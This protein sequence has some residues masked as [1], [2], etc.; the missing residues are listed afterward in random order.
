MNW[1]NPTSFGN[2]PL[3][4]SQPGEVID[5]E[6]RVVSPPRSRLLATTFALGT[7]AVSV[8]LGVANLIGAIS[9]QDGFVVLAVLALAAIV[10]DQS[11]LN[12]GL[13]GSQLWT[14]AALLGLACVVVLFAAGE[15]L[16]GWIF[17]A[18]GLLLGV[19]MLF[20]RSVTRK[21]W[22]YVL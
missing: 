7:A 15:T 16:P 11:R 6:V 10:I 5:A 18:V 21:G 1:I 9:A 14:A 20:M 8:G 19:T 3:V 13:R 4:R 22:R 17:A 12:R 2:K